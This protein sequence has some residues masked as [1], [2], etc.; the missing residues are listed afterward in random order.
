MVLLRFQH[1]VGGHA[2]PVILTTQSKNTRRRGKTRW[3]WRESNP[4]RRRVEF[5]AN[6]VRL[7]NRQGIFFALILDRFGTFGGLNPR[8]ELRNREIS[9]LSPCRCP[10]RTKLR[11][12]VDSPPIS[13]RPLA[14]PKPQRNFH[15]ETSAMSFQALN[16]TLCDNSSERRFIVPTFQ[17]RVIN[18]HKINSPQ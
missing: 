7:P 6:A 16:V 14:H 11:L 5:I 9:A 2:P 15:D 4:A 10:L 12:V 13:H 18:P 1:A 17:S 8:F 3:S